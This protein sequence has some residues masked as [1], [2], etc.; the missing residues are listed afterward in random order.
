M[1]SNVLTGQLTC[2][3]DENR[4][5]RLVQ[6]VVLR[7]RENRIE[8]AL[9]LLSNAR[10]EVIKRVSSLPMKQEV[11]ELVSQAS[12]LT[13]LA[14]LHYLALGNRMDEEIDD[15]RRL[16][17]LCESV[18]IGNVL[19]GVL[20]PILMM[21]N[22]GVKGNFADL[23]QPAENC[24]EELNKEV[25]R[26][27]SLVRNN[28]KKA[29]KTLNESIRKIIS[30][31]DPA[32]LEVR[33]LALELGRRF[34]AGNFK[35]ARKIYEFVRDEIHYMRDPLLFEDIQSPAT[36]LKRAT[37]DC[38][39][40]AVLL[41]SLL[42]AIGFETALLFADTDGDST[43]DHV[44][45]AVYIPD[46]PEL[47]KPLANKYIDGKALRDWIPLDPTCEDLDFGV[48]TL[49]NLEIKHAFF[50]CKERQY[51]ISQSSQ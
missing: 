2:L 3:E 1:D 12:A 42:L 32:S 27:I 30:A 50:F 8:D 34:E 33:N 48:I 49:D 29:D 15:V 28:S 13:Y 20:L 24:R 7:I 16:V 14:M 37:G 31:V 41:C 22:H 44:Y 21:D 38:D 47:Y 40:K 11:L 9:S 5:K 45:S 19:E 6:D 10:K 51:L 26:L 43:P 4:L 25:A 46:A 39:D 17:Y 18:G 23:M 35:Q 36:T